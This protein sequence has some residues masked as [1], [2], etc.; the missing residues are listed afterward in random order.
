MI[1]LQASGNSNGTL[2]STTT[3]GFPQ[4][5]SSISLFLDCI[6]A[7]WK[8]RGDEVLCVM[9]AMKGGL[10]IRGDDSHTHLDV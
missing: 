2:I 4:N 10:W 9:R 1:S 5:L 7:S 6:G 8:A 3:V